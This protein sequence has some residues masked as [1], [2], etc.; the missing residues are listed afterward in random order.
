MMVLALGVLLTAMLLMKL[1]YRRA[2]PVHLGSMSPQ[3]VIDYHS[4]WFYF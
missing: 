1:G 2:S 4:A 3:W